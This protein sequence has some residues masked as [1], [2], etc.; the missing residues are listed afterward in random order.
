MVDFNKA[1]KKQGKGDNV[2]NPFVAKPSSGGEIPD[3]IEAG[4]YP[5]VLIALV[6]L[7]TQENDY[8]G[9]TSY[10]HEIYLAWEIHTDDNETVVLGKQYALTMT[11]KSNLGKLIASLSA[12]GKVPEKEVDLTTLLGMGCLIQV[13]ATTRK[14]DSG[15][16]RTYNAAETASRLP[17]GMPKPTPVRKPVA[18]TL[19][20][21]VPDWLPR[22][23]GTTLADLRSL[24]VEKNSTTATKMAAWKESKKSAGGSSSGDDTRPEAE[25]GGDGEDEVLF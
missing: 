11:P 9:V 1:I 20:E 23:Y 12:S 7:G 3:A 2:S 10:R 4:N 18:I 24:S 15:Q 17:K 8:K 6:D 16:E 5:A 21:Q 14:N 19:D 22:S 25:A 13:S